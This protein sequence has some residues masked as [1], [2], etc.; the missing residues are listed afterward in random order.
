MHFRNIFQRSIAMPW[1]GVTVARNKQQ[2]RKHVTY[3]SDLLKQ[4][5]CT[6]TVVIASKAMVLDY[7]GQR[8]C[9]ISIGI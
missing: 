8:F 6:K 2:R 3:F 5:S 7:N 9:Q 1:I 4:S